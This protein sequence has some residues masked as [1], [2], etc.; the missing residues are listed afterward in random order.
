MLTLPAIPGDGP[1]V[2]GSGV[3][4]TFAHAADEDIWLQLMSHERQ[5]GTPASLS[6]LPIHC[7]TYPKTLHKL[8]AGPEPNLSRSPG[9]GPS[10]KKRNPTPLAYGP[11]SQELCGLTP[12]VG[13]YRN[14]CRVT[15]DKA[16]KSWGPKSLH[17]VF[18]RGRGGVCE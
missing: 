2:P 1:R 11:T 13:I 16:N 14:R 7:L 12:A 9:I 15:P 17:M 6:L 10:Y 8:L 5:G 4:P 18:L 3:G